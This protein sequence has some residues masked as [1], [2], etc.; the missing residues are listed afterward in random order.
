[1]PLWLWIPFIAVSYSIGTAWYLLNALVHASCHIRVE[2]EEY[3]Q[4]RPNHIFCS[5]HTDVGPYIVAF[6][7]LSNQIWISHPVWY[8]KPI[9]V[10]ARYVGIKRVLGSAGFGG[11]QAL[12]SILPYLRDGWS[13][14]VFTDGP[15]GPAKVVKKGVLLMS[16]KTGIP[17]IPLRIIASRSCIWSKSWDKKHYPLPF[18]TITIRYGAPIQVAENIEEAKCQLADALNSMSTV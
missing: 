12:E 15:G 10:V 14:T 3:L 13:T 6:L 7:R 5:W 8:M 16:L 9:Y 4:G 17:I 2:G 11:M 18:S 1:M